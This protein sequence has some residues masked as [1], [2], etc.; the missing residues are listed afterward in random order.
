MKKKKLISF[1]VSI[2]ILIILSFELG[3]FGDDFKN[4]VDDK[5][6]DREIVTLI[7]PVDGDTANF[8]TTSYGRVNVRF[9]AVNTPETKHPTLGLEYYGKEASAFTEQYLRD[10]KV[11]EIEW[12]LTQ[13]PSR[14]RPIGIIFV[15]DINLNILL[16][17]E[18]YGDLRYLEESMPYAKEYIEA[19]KY[20]QENKLG[21]WK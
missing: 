14:N 5:V 8:D 18:G 2:I 1:I 12:D 20:A 17:K 19:L 21:R 16:V 13:S 6:S 11:I 4:I 10:A 15:D 9:S 7:R 3:G